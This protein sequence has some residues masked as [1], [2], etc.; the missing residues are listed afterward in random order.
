MGRSW[1]CCWSNRRKLLLQHRADII[2]S[3]TQAAVTS[4]G[5]TKV[6]I[7]KQTVEKAA[8]NLQTGDKIDFQSVS[9]NAVVNLPGRCGS[10]KQ[11]RKEYEYQR[12]HG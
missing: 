12:D 5:Q 4:G 6:V 7:G 2:D 8:A 3:D 1:E 10:N 9:E 11:H